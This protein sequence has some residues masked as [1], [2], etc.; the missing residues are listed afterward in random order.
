MGLRP[1]GAGPFGAE[2]QGGT[3]WEWCQDHY[4]AYKEQDRV[5]PGRLPLK[6]M[7]LTKGSE[8]SEKWKFADDFSPVLRG[9]SWWNPAWLLRCADRHWL[10]PGLQGDVIGFRL[11]LRP[12]AS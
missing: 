1:A 5:D 3:V 11:L 4:R 12:P 10:P 2:E 7:W 9:G 6:E 8:S